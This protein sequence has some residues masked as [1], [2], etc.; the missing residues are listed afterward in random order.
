MFV[1][2]VFLEGGELNTL[3]VIEPRIDGEIYTAAYGPGGNY[4]VSGGSDKI[5]KVWDARNG[6]LVKNLYGHE[7]IV[8]SAVYSPDGNRIVSSAGDGTVIIWDVRT[9]KKISVLKGHTGWVWQVCFSPDG[10]RVVSASADKTLRVWDA[11]S[12]EELL[13]ISA[14]DSAV[15]C[16]RYSPDGKYIASASADGVIKLW[17]GESGGEVRRFEGGSG[18]LWSLAYSPDGRTIASGAED[19]GISI[20]DVQTGL[21]RNALKQDGGAVYALAYSPDGE[22]IAAGMTGAVIK[23][24]SAKSF[25]PGASFYGHSA[26]VSALDFS[27]DSRRLLSGS[28]DAFLKVWRLSDGMAQLSF[29]GVNLTV[30]SAAWDSVG[31]KSRFVSGGEGGLITVWDAD[32]RRQILTLSGHSGEARQAAY[33]GDG[34]LIV[35]ASSDKTVK[36]WDA[37]TGRETRALEGH[38]G[39]VNAAVFSPDSKR[40]VSASN[41]KTLK[42]WDSQ[43]GKVLFTLTHEEAVNCAAYSPDGRFVVSG[44]SGG[45]AGGGGFAGS[46]GFTGGGAAGGGAGGAAVIIWDANTKREPLFVLRGHRAPVNSVAYSRDGR[47]VISASDDETVKVWNAETGKE[48]LTFR[49]H[50]GAVLSAAFS[51][52]G[53]RALSGDEN[54]VVKEWDTKTGRE[55]RTLGRLPGEVYTVSY[56]ADGRRLLAGGG[57]GVIR[58]WNAADGREEAMFSR[59]ADGEWVCVS[60]DGF[61]NSS[62]SGAE[63]VMLRISGADG[64]RLYNLESFRSL[65]YRGGRGGGEGAGETFGRSDYSGYGAVLSRAAEFSPPELA[66]INPRNGENV[67]DRL[68]QL[69]FAASYKNEPIE[70]IKVLLNGRLIASNDN[71]AF[72][73]SR[74]L[75][76]SAHEI[77]IDNESRE[78]KFPVTLNAGSNFIEAY[79][80]NRYAEVKD[81]VELV[82]NNVPANERRRLPNLWVFAIGVGAYND[83]AIPNLDWAPFDARDITNMFKRQ[84]GKLY[85]RVNTVV[86]ADKMS[87]IPSQKSIMA[88]LNYFKQMSPQDTAVFFIAG[89]GF[90]DADGEFYLLPRDAGYK[91]D[92]TI[93]RSKAISGKSLF[94]M[95]DL[96]CQK[97]ILLDLYGAEGI[98]GREDMIIDYNGLTRNLQRSNA[99]II[100]SCG[101]IENAQ[102]MNK[103]KHGVFAYA[104]MQGFKGEADLIKDNFIGI[105][106]LKI[107]L[108]GVIP[109]LTMSMQHP[110][111]SVPDSFLFFRAARIR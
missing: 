9:W 100:S 111:A 56:S 4:V 95:L 35:S 39:A 83:S 34:N 21:L 105:D 38:T 7:S 19:G 110:V 28:F 29:G 90:T 55:L 5:L 13:F 94:S 62:P 68:A 37:N 91:K 70:S 78:Y 32:G 101:G 6:R 93:D 1:A 47:R 65:L 45:F 99:A 77:T 92:G 14:H 79:A 42:I 12:G 33:S 89:R 8:S 61:Y 48:V 17:D 74:Q 96:P 80:S 88:R 54:C 43:A 51:P 98:D 30:K 97:I 31:D 49:G 15:R 82:W 104:I 69:E 22:R 75:S 87:V 108:N 58:I 25:Y 107:Y 27:P 36:I 41:D 72:S 73:S 24:W 103:D 46:G 18:A 2:G 16:A 64:R 10:S 66:I 53:K 76:K 67:M 109:K 84:R 52:D 20:W 3:A 106:E 60:P 81:S 11:R 57:G 85:E 50:N 23:T 44:S 102:F 63:N 40:I 71:S 86:I 26:A 59:Y